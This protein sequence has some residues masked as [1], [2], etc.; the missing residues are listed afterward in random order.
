MSVPITETSP[1]EF[2]SI[3]FFMKKCLLFLT[4]K[5]L[6]V[7]AFMTGKYGYAFNRTVPSG[8]EI[9]PF[10]IC[11]EF[12]DY[13]GLTINELEYLFNK[14]EFKALTVTID[15]VK[16]YYGSYDKFEELTKTKKQIY[17]MWSILNVLKCKTLDNYWREFGSIFCNFSNPSIKNRIQQLLN[18]EKLFITLYD[19]TRSRTYPVPPP[20]IAAS[21]TL[22]DD[23]LIFFI[24]NLLDLGYI[25]SDTA[26]IL[27]L[28]CSNMNRAITMK[29][30]N[31]EV[32]QDIK[33]KLSLLS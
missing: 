15:E 31:Q 25:T 33:N 14:N 3:L 5:E 4:K 21:G 2:C 7:R 9:K 18:D 30:P 1:Q 20:I 11:H 6:V 32:R 27:L 22:T 28:F 12:T 10:F 19:A 23:S 29:I 13:Y 8:I 26:P 17:C 24:T 16:A